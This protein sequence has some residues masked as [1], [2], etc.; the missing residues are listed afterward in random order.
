LP[1]IQI[2]KSLKDKTRDLTI[3][4]ALVIYLFS[5]SLAYFWSKFYN[6]QLYLSKLKEYNKKIDEEMGGL[7]TKYRKLG[8][9]KNFLY[10]RKIP[11]FF[12][13]ELYKITPQQIALNYINIDDSG[14]IIIRG[15]GAMLSDTFKYVSTLENSKFFKDVTTKY[16][17][18][19]K[20]QDRDVT[21]FEF[22]V[23]SEIPVEKLKAQK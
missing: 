20:I 21:E 2:R 22:D 13:S 15:Q 4:G 17:R 1:E 9:V 8:L 7:V 19:K 10:Q 11:L 14:T 6:Q 18:T 23:E 5:A 12:L 16:T 3:L